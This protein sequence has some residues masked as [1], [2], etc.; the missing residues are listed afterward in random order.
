[1]VEQTAFDNEPTMGRETEEGAGQKNTPYDQSGRRETE[2]EWVGEADQTFD[3]VF[4]MD[5][6]RV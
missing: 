4:L 6:F 2:E 1:M 3:W 5:G